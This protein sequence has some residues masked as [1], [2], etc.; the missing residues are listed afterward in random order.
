MSIDLFSLRVTQTKIAEKELS[1]QSTTFFYLIKSN[2][3]LIP[4]EKR[5]MWKSVQ[6]CAK[7]V[8]ITLVQRINIF[9][10]KLSA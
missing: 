5:T 3:F 1:N 9:Y 8:Q 2:H 10:D 6:F 4:L 7:Y